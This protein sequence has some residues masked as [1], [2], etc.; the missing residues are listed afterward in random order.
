LV[1]R[2]AESNLEATP[3]PI[4]GIAAFRDRGSGEFREQALHC[5]AG[6]RVS[7]GGCRKRASIATD[8][9]AAVTL[10]YPR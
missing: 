10:F 1:T 7:L 4:L 8:Q 2:A 3:Q 5:I 9:K 6:F